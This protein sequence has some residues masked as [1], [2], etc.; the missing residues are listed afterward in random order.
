[1][2]PLKVV[3]LIAK[4]LSPRGSELLPGHLDDRLE[5]PA[6]Q[7]PQLDLELWVP[8]HSQELGGPGKLQ[9]LGRPVG[10][11][12]DGPQARSEP[13]DGLVDQDATD[14]VAR[15]LKRLESSNA[16]VAVAM[17][18][19]PCLDSEAIEGLLAAADDLVQRAGTLNLV[20]VTGPL[21]R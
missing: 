6:M 11:P 9:G 14:F 8:L 10:R 21:P 2:I 7:R 5:E 18:D 15:L 19:V 12:G 1:M 17:E 16:R 13:I 20:N 4:G 3:Q